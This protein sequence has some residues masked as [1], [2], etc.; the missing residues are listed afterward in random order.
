MIKQF[1]PDSFEAPLTHESNH[2]CFVP[3]AP[4]VAAKDHEAVMS[5]VDSLKGIFGKTSDW[6]K[7]SL[8]L[9]ENTKSLEQH[10]YEF[11]KK[12]AFAYSVFNST[13]DLCLGSIYIDPSQSS[14]FDCDVYFWIR[15]SHIHLETE[16]KN[17][18]DAWFKAV[19]PFKAVAYPGRE[20]SWEAWE[21]IIETN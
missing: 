7:A 14:Q 18:I 5:S 3:L 1:I 2:F 13:K 12:L 19:W 11:E 16:L 15:D 9:V 6:P 17:E 4:P 10:K 21:S 20:I 8:T